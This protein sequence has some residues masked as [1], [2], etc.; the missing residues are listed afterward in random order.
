MTLAAA[1]LLAPAA[2]AQTDV[3]IQY[4]HE[5]YLKNEAGTI[6]YNKYLVS[7]QPNNEGEYTLRIENFVTG[8]I[9]S[10]AV[11]T[12]FV[13][14]LDCSGSM[15]FDY[16][17]GLDKRLAGVDC[18]GTDGETKTIPNYISVADNNRVKFLTLDNHFEGYDRYTYVG[19]CR[20]GDYNA[21][22]SAYV[23]TNTQWF[24]DENGQDAGTCSRY[25]YYE[26]NTTPSNTGYYLIY[27]KIISNARNLCI[28]L[29]DG[30]E[31][32]LYQ[33]TVHDTPNTVC[34][35]NTRVIYLGD[36]WRME[37][38]R[39]ALIDALGVFTRQIQEQNANDGQWREGETRHRIAIVSFGSEYQTNNSTGHS[40]TWNDAYLVER[41]NKSSY[42]KLVKNFT[43]VSS[44]NVSATQNSF[45]D[46]V[47]NRMQFGGYTDIDYGVHMAMRLLATE[48]VKPGM[49][50][51]TP[52]GAAN[53]NKVVVVVTDGSPN[54]NFNDPASTV[55]MNNALADGITIK[56]TGFVSGTT[57]HINGKIF[58][59]DL[60]CASYSPLF[61]GRL[62]S[63]YPDGN[64]VGTDTASNTDEAA[65]TGTLI[66]QYDDIHDPQHEHDLRFYYQ[67]A[68]KADL[69][70]IFKLIAD[71][72][73]GETKQMVAVDVMSDDFVI[74]FTTEEVNRVKIYTAECI[75]KKTIDGEEFLAFAREIEAPNRGALAHLWVPEVGEDDEVEWK[76]LGAS[77]P[78]DLDGTDDAPK[79]SFKVDLDGKRIILRGFNY[80]EL[81]CGFDPDENHT[82]GEAGNTRQMAADDPNA[83]YALPGYRGFKMIF[84]FPIVLDP[85]ALGGVN[86]PTNDIDASGL[87]ISDSSGMPTSDAQVNYPTPNLPV[88]VRL[89]IQ[90]SGLNKGESANF[91]VQ[92]RTRVPGSEWEDYTTF[93]LTGEEN[94]TPEIRIINLDPAYFY[95]VKEENWSWAYTNVHPEYTTEPDA[96]G[97]TISNPIVFENVPIPT[98]Q[99]AE[100]KATNKMRSWE[101]SSTETVNSK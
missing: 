47:N 2:F 45:V 66:P 98:P 33:T 18:T 81:Y 38:R 95:K 88:P 54:N 80:T 30:T 35:A 100:A 68:S 42:T 22:G 7:T 27:R 28:R 84:E 64:H 52:Q 39:E 46:A 82:T 11:P 37:T 19:L 49:A 74:P 65:Y 87:F 85:D 93:V 96:Q 51:L 14:V 94:N 72:S 36:T 97:K 31:K 99:H 92:R 4:Q 44:A 67:D 43:V 57:Q 25:Y 56:K 10:H 12:D 101:A 78:Y 63:N 21:N 15:Q 75:G 17:L 34:T 1:L 58:A 48:Q 53:R 29:Q 16:R 13:L 5:K 77:G 20:S 24:R 69:S 71:A 50:P 55:T 41:T 59:I 70:E 91:T 86:V 40:T 61:L 83:S 79:I 6:G 9:K 26:D 60:W 73:S 62:S 32:Y 76:D 23:S 90:K 89:I 8:T 3:P